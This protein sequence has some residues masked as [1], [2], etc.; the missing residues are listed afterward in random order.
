MHY[1]AKKDGKKKR[2]LRRY[3]DAYKPK[4]DKIKRS[5]KD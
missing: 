2:E 3:T 4:A 5:L 1:K